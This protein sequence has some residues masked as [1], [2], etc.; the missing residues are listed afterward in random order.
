MGLKSTFLEIP[1][2]LHWLAANKMARYLPGTVSEPMVIGHVGSVQGTH[3]RNNLTLSDY[4]DSGCAVQV[5]T[6]S[7]IKDKWSF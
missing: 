1:F 7:L 6:G 3:G 5:K 2:T 4:S